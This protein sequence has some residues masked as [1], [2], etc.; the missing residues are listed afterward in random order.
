MTFP[1]TYLPTST[2]SAQRTFHTLD[3]YYL[4]RTLTRLGSDYGVAT[5]ADDAALADSIQGAWG[6][7]VKTGVPSTVPAWPAYAPATPGDLASVSVLRFAVPNTTVTGTL[8]RSGRCAALAPVANLLDADHDIATYD[9]DNCPRVANTSQADSDG[10]GVGDACDDCTL[11]PNPD[12]R[13]AD[14]DGYGNACDADLTND[15]IVN[16]GDLAKMK[17]VFFKADESADLNGDH[18]VNFADLA[19]MKKSFFK[20]PGPAAGKP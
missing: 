12:Q 9:E 14:H 7:F 4:F 10:D 19:I 13:D 6:S 16:F 1:P 20:K 17:S 11:V 3:L 18:V 8:F 5:D 15:G 2:Q